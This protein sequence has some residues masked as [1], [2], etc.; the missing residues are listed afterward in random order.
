MSNN[1]TEQLETNLNEAINPGQSQEHFMAELSELMYSESLNSNKPKVDTQGNPT[2]Y[3]QFFDSD[4]QVRQEITGDVKQYLQNQ[5]TTENT[6]FLNKLQSYNVVALSGDNLDGYAGMV[7]SPKDYPE[8]GIL[9]NRGS[10]NPLTHPNDWGNNFD[11]WATNGIERP[12]NSLQFQTAKQLLI[13]ARKNQSDLTEISTTGHSQGGALAIAMEK[14]IYQTDGLTLGETYAFNPPGF[15]SSAT[16]GLDFADIEIIK[17][18]THIYSVAGDPVSETFSDQLVT[19]EKI[20]TS[21]GD[22]HAMVNLTLADR[23]T[24]LDTVISDQ[25][26]LLSNKSFSENV[27]LE[28]LNEFG[29]GDSTNPYTVLE[30]AKL[31]K[32]GLENM[33]GE[34]DGY[35]DVATNHQSIAE[36]NAFMT[37]AAGGSAGESL[38]SALISSINNLPNAQAQKTFLDVLKGATILG[39]ILSYDNMQDIL[40]NMA[41]QLAQENRQAQ[42]EQVFRGDPL[43]LDLDNDGIETM[44]VNEG[45]LFDH[46]NKQVR[47]GTG[48]ISEDDGLLVRDL[49][50][51]NTIDSG[52]EL[53]GDN[54]IKSDGTKAVDG[55]DALSDL[56]STA[57]GVFDSQDQAF[58]EVQVWQDKNQDGISQ[59]NELKSL[60]EAGIESIDLAHNDVNQ[61]TAGG[62][63][64]DL[65]SYKKTDGSIA[66][67]GNLFLDKEPARSEF[68]DKIE[69]SEA[70]L[71][72]GV[73]I[74]GIGATRN[75]SQAAS[76]NRDLAA[77]LTQMSENPLQKLPTENLLKEWAKSANF[78]DTLD[79]E[80]LVLEDGTSFKFDLSNDTR[81]M[82]EK[83]QTLETFTG[84]KIIQT[85]VEG[86]QLT[87]TYG[88]V[89]MS[90]DIAL[91]QENVLNDAVVSN[92]WMISGRTIAIDVG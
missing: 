85:N 16:D 33:L 41:D 12:E 68:T 34:F 31:E 83:I 54:T 43:T 10:E 20:Y 36:I 39:E 70:V 84:N 86:N 13:D 52:R 92:A 57:D 4:G 17:S 81:E 5:L 65:G 22:K 90:Y 18:K 49:D 38:L 15:A 63:I 2:L 60:T 1:T 80:G 11:M 24:L 78:S 44:S 27:M 56:D 21:S 30:A 51:S 72:V 8:E 23:L 19:P 45:I 62:V 82:L 66:E 76:L 79:L 71:D 28:V 69:I 37:T 55:F 53:F 42:E 59:A 14:V 7:V 91:G 35:T 6:Q 77:I 61:A 25:E 40:T 32:Q 26:L 73:D 47:E 89:N 29:Q 3:A 87:M 74:R 88:N 46:E 48:W 58:D 67:I 64:S 50:N 9:I 75:L